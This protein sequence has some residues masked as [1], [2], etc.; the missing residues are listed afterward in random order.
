MNALLKKFYETL[1]PLWDFRLLLVC[2]ICLG[3]GFSVDTSATQGML[4]FCLFVPVIWAVALTISKILRP[5][6]KSSTLARK[7]TE[8]SMGAAVV[9]AANRLLLIAIGLSFVLWWARP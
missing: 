1:K 3:I 2:A 9:Y 5:E 7:A 8:T 4:L 6:I